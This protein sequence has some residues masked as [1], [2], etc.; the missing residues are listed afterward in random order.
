[1]SDFDFHFFQGINKC[2]NHLIILNKKLQYPTW[3]WIHMWVWHFNRTWHWWKPTSRDSNNLTAKWET[4]VK[5]VQIKWHAHTSQTTATQKWHIYVAENMKCE[6][7]RQRP[8][9]SNCFRAICSVS[10][11]DG[12]VWFCICFINTSNYRFKMSTREVS[13]E[14]ETNTCFCVLNKIHKESFQL[15]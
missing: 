6:H 15:V 13:K 9:T 10:F 8:D 7:C 1:M 3:K 11:L 2:I 12:G 4:R 5:A 14:I